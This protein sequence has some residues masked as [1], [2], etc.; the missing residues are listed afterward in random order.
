MSTE[1]HIHTRGAYPTSRFFCWPIS[2]SL[3]KG[4]DLSWTQ[5]GPSYGIAGNDQ[6]IAEA[7]GREQ[8]KGCLENFPA[9]GYGRTR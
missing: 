8:A 2:S 1:N 9:Q 3:C 4:W 6:D 7:R 5:S